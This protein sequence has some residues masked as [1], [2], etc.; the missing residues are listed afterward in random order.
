MLAEINQNEREQK[1]QGHQTIGQFLAAKKEEQRHKSRGENDHVRGR[2]LSRRQIYNEFDAIWNYQSQYHGGLLS[3]KNRWGHRPPP[4]SPEAAIKPS[5]P[6]S[7]HDPIRRNG[8]DFESFGVEGILFFQRPMYWP[9][10]VIGLCELEPKEKR[11]PRADRRAE[12]FRVLQEVNNL[13]HVDPDNGSPTELS[14][15]QRS[16]L[17]DMLSRKKKVDFGQIR[18]KL[19]F[20]DSVKFNLERGKRSSIKGM[21]LDVAFAAKIGEQWYDWDDEKRDAIVELLRE[22]QN[23]DDRLF[24]TFVDELGL[25]EDQ[26]DAALDIDLP[27]GYVM[28]SRVAIDRLLPHLERGLIYQS[29]SDPEKSALHAAGYLRRDELQRRLFDALPD[30]ARV[31]PAVC[32]L[33]DLPNP[34][35][36]RALYELRKVVNAIIREYGKPD[37]VHVEMARSLQMGQEKRNEYNKRIRGNEKER[38]DAA[39]ALRAVGERPTRDAILKYRLWQQQEH[40][41]MY[42]NKPI[43]QNQLFG[44]ATDIDHILPRSLTLDDSQANKVL[45]HRECNAEK[46]QQTPYQ[47]LRAERLR[48]LRVDLPASCKIIT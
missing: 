2:H 46:A 21:T 44:G 18:K 5:K 48:P 29:V 36:K 42:C 10:S 23:D 32:K 24:A 6:I 26:A 11:C 39:E 7:H 37:E 27:I 25:T 14:P 47:W 43:S 38:E 3:D 8:S 33:G 1:E 15:E 20:L 30:F 17:L 35:V 22:N 19:G 31:S 16:L 34:V 4:E 45:C 12:R 9:K 40:D 28:L 13:R 41:C